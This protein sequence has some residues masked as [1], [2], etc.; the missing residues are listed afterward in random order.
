HVTGWWRIKAEI[1]EGG[2]ER[3]AEVNSETRTN[4]PTPAPVIAGLPTPSNGTSPF[5]Y[6][7]L[8][9]L[10]AIR[11][12]DFSVRMSG[13]Q[14]GLNGKIADA[15]NDIAAA[16]QRMAHNLARV[17]QDVGRAGNTRQRVKLGIS[18]GSWG[19]MED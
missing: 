9:A 6:E 1:R 15:F 10:H 8:H 2:M 3:E 14:L 5:E 12:G 17:G 13:D 4:G 16:N 11:T 7:L 19:D 18:N